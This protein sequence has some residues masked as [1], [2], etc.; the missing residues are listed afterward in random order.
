MGGFVMTEDF[1]LCRTVSEL[2]DFTFII[3]DYQRGYRW[4]SEDVNYLLDDISGFDVGSQ[5]EPLFYYL[6]PLVVR[7]LDEKTFEVVDGQQRL[8][9]IFIIMKFAA[10][11]MKSAKCP[12]SL[13]YKT[14]KGSKHYLDNLGISEVIDWGNIDYYHITLARKTIGSWLNRQ[15]DKAEAITDLYKRLMSSTRF[16]WYELPDDVD[17]KVEFRKL[18]V[19][20]IR[21][22]NAELIK[23]LLLSKDNFKNEPH[24][25]LINKRQDEISIAWDSIEQHLQQPLFWSFISKDL[26]SVSRIDLIFEIIAH[27]RASSLQ[28]PPKEDDIYYSFLVLYQYMNNSD[29]QDKLVEEIWREVEAVYDRFCDWYNDPDKYHLIG[30]LT[31]SGVDVRRILKSCENIPNSHVLTELKRLTIDM[32]KYA[33]INFLTDLVYDN[34]TRNELR[35][36]LLLFNIAT[37]ICKSERQDRFPFDVYVEYNWDIEHIHA[38]KDKLPG[39]FEDARDYLLALQEEFEQ[40]LVEPSDDSDT[41]KKQYADAIIALKEFLGKSDMKLTDAEEFYTDLRDTYSSIIQ[42]DNNIRNLALLD[43]KTNRGYKNVSYRQKRRTIIERDSEGRF[44]PLCTRNVFLKYYSPDAKR[45]SRWEES[46]RE[47]YKQQISNTLSDFFKGV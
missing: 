5:K 42:E 19:G 26:L 47:E 11:E 22:T 41:I 9:T 31:Q 13:D 7:K 21:L 27:N 43:S 46:E 2:R 12:Y 23:A 17:P 33:D 32:K 15:S 16:I 30:Y 29:A 28:W 24:A 39:K 6:Q 3:P 35:K 10:D 18:N 4:T 1:M 40:L 34:R 14:R 37:L 36:L 45:L 8:T 25:M 44:I 38:I 20:K